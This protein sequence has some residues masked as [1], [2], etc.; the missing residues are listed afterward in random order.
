MSLWQTSKPNPAWQRDSHLLGFSECCAYDAI[1]VAL[2]I[3]CLSLVTIKIL[4]FRQPEAPM[5]CQTISRTYRGDG[6]NTT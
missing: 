3:A 4:H 6:K 5:I 2:F 1:H